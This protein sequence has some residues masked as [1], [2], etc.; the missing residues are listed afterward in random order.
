M[1]T[2]RLAD[3]R[4]LESE[5]TSGDEE[6]GLNL[7]VFRVDSFESRNDEGGCFTGTVLG[8][9]ENVATGESDRNSFLLN[10]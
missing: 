4:S 10:W 5:F 2:E 3:L 6:E 8:S 7:G 9:S 1:F